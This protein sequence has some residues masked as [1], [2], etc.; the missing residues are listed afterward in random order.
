MDSLI[1][2]SVPNIG[3]REMLYVSQTLR[4]GWVSTAGPNIAEFERKLAAYCK[5]PGAVACQSGTAGLHL[6]MLALGIA[7][8]DE[9]FVP[10]LTFA[11]A[12]NPVRY[13][14]AE[15]VFI[16][17][18][19]SLCMDMEQLMRF[20]ETECDYNGIQLINKRTK[21]LLKAVV[22]V[23]VFGN[24]ADMDALMAIAEKYN[25]R[26]VE[27][28]TEALGS[29]IKEGK[30]SGKFA[31]TIGDMGVYSFNGNKI[32]TTGSGGM[33]VARNPVLLERV[34]YLSTQA[35]DDEVYFIHNEIGYNYR[36]TA[37]QAALG[38][39]QIERLEEFIEQK[40]RNY[41]SYRQKG[42]ALHPFRSDIRP[43]YWFYSLLTNQRDHVIQTLATQ[44]IQ[45]RPIW[46]L[47]HMQKPYQNSQRG[48]I[49]R[50]VYYL[51]RIVNIPCSTGL[52]EK[53]LCRVVQAIR[54]LDGGGSCGC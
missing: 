2:L 53:E 44:K 16:D 6:S 19:D 24:I 14:G 47:I 35:K 23:H 5:A 52:E 15:P 33:V 21:R 13:V 51:E 8:G 9:I 3:E 38:L 42:M 18:D 32:M 29:Y 37:V 22:V 31:G 50:A 40:R 12:V 41:Y 11:A 26:V 7:Q 34:R 1:P 17:C 48:E 20:I 10:T 28:A 36:M 25:L 46:Q 43:N 54:A 49:S 27:D 39:A 30:F 45:T 4:E